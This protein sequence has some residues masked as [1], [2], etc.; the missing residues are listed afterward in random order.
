[1]T[2]YVHYGPRRSW[3]VARL[4]TRAINGWKPLCG[5]YI[6]TTDTMEDLPQARSCETCLRIN[7]RREDRE[8]DGST[9]DETVL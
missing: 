4:H 5:L 6:E 1:M 9:H 7:Q 2:T 8:D 3:H